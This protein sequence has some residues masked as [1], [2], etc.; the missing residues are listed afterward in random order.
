M[1]TDGAAGRPRS[2][3]GGGR[4][5]R[6][7]RWSPAP[8]GRARRRRTCRGPRAG[9]PRGAGR[10]G[11]GRSPRGS[12]R[13]PGDRDGRG[14]DERCQPCG[15]VFHAEASLR[16]QVEL[17]PDAL[18]PI[19]A[20]RRPTAR[21]APRPAA[22]RGRARR[23]RPRRCTRAGWW[24]RRRRPRPAGRRRSTTAASRTAVPPPCSRA[25][26][27]SSVTS[28]TAVSAVSGPNA[29]RGAEIADDGLGQSACAAASADT[30]RVALS[31]WWSIRWSPRSV[32]ATDTRTKG[33]ETRTAIPLRC[34]GGRHPLRR[35]TTTPRRAC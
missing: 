31:G 6:G 32:T 33:E 21:R 13:G 22:A 10:R 16:G 9:R 35:P 34:C 8:R 25:L 4:R 7:G 28:S 19:R 11:R 24:G 3:R 27:T 12:R 15:A 1:A 26:V 5:R 30:T 2:G 29:A 18:A 17:E 23:R 14:V 20:A